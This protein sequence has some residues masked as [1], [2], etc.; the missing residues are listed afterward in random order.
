LACRFP[1]DLVLTDV[2]MP[3][4]DGFELLRRLRSETATKTIPV[5]LLSARAGEESR[6]EGLN[7]GADDYLVKPFTSS[8]LLARVAAHL[9]LAKTRKEA[10]ERLRIANKELESFAYSVSHDLRGPLRGIDGWSLALLEDYG[11]QLAPR[12]HQYLQ[13]VRSEAQRM[14]LL[15][16]DLLEL[17]RIT[18]AD[19]RT[20]AVDLSALAN[21]VADRLCDGAPDRKIDFV[22]ERGLTAVGDAPLLDVALA[23]LFGNAVKFTGRLES[24]RIE[25]GQSGNGGEKLFYVKDNGIGFDMAHAKMLFGAFQR[26]HKDT[27]FPGTGIGLATVQR[28]IHRH[29]GRVWAEAEPEH[30]AT[31]YFT[32]P[33]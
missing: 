22:I 27:D 5:I 4:M 32:L 19:M 11:A 12:A 23:N 21:A 17:S 3:R 13:R 28:V 24:A 10:A 16:D 6:V 18:C 26:F 30:G 20:A 25:F 15:I 9:R 8:E 31:F 14:G 2:M 1:V 33:G 7:A 29:G